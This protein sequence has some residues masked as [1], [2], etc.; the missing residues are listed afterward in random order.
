MGL[1]FVKLH[2]VV[3]F[4]LHGPHKEIDVTNWKTV[5]HPCNVK[6]AKQVPTIV[7]RRR[8]KNLLIILIFQKQQLHIKC[9]YSRYDELKNIKKYFKLNQ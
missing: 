8:F 4:Q 3:Q 7:I 1:D 2:Q 6:A 9:N 5:F